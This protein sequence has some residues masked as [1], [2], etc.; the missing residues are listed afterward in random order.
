[1]TPNALAST[2]PQAD[3]WSHLKSM[4]HALVRALD[5]QSA[6]SLTT[7]DKERLIALVSFLRNSLVHQTEEQLIS[8][9][10]LITPDLEPNTVSYLD[11]RQRLKELPSFEAWENKAKMGFDK[12]VQKLVETTEN[13]INKPASDSLF[14]KDAP[15]EELK[16]LRDLLSELL[17]NSESALHT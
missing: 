1:M 13:Y 14:P 9:D 17:K 4:D 10:S 12:K 16:V 2:G 6:L 5:S 8:M 15:Q 11:L 3:L 7:L